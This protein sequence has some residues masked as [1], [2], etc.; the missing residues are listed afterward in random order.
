MDLSELTN[1]D[2]KTITTWLTTTG[3]QILIILIVAFVCYRLLIVASRQITLRIQA[4]DD[5]QNSHHDRRAETFSQLLRTSGMVVIVTVAVLMI[6]D[7]VGINIG[8]LIASVGVAS[9]ALGLGLQTLVKDV[10]SGLFLIIEDQYHIGDVIEVGGTFGTVENMTL[11][12]TNIRDVNGYIHFVPNGEIRV[13]ANRSRD[14]SRAIIDVGITYDDD[15]DQALSLLQEIGDAAVK[16]G[17]IG[18]L[19]LEAPVVTG[20]EGLDDWQVRLRIMVKTVA[21]TQFE[22]QRYIRARI[23]KEFPARGI[24]IASPR[25]EVVLFQNG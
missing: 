22:V 24:T 5:E 11:R 13:V 18:P 21:G 3:L 1:F 14:W 9:L 6:L 7:Q 2:V 23:R 19:I 17:E 16:D 25:Q 20:V 8:P 12:V 15:L 10:I 4:M